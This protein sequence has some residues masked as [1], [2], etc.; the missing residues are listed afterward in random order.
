MN[1]LVPPPSL[2]AMCIRHLITCHSRGTLVV[3]YWPT[4]TFWPLLFPDGKSGP[5]I[6][7]LLVFPN[8]S[9]YLVA[10]TSSNYIFHPDRFKGSFLACY[11]DATSL[12]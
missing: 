2:I 5:C 12:D 9:C 8:A 1:W 3:P 4:A 10:G 7:E 11:L 6:K